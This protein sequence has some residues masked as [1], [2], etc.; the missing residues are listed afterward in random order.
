MVG[1]ESSME[2][3]DAAKKTKQPKVDAAERER[4]KKFYAQLRRRSAPQP[5]TAK[6]K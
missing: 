4:Q 3:A 5:K 6:Y 2:Q 1:L